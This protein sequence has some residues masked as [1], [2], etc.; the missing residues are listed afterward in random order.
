MTEGRPS[1]HGAAVHLL[2]LCVGADSI[3]DLQAWQAARA[4][5]RARTADPRPRHVTRMWPRRA[6]ELTGGGSL[7][8]V[9]RGMIAV[10]QQVE[11]LE[12]VTG[13]DGITRCA[14]VLSPRLSRVVPRP[15]RAFQGWRYLAAADAPADLPHGV[16][17]DGAPLPPELALALSALGVIGD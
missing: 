14:I 7:F 3:E 4:A 2:K 1:A 17:T 12:P 15:H 6:E 10:R 5:E 9:I 16:G 8:W 13:A 11:A